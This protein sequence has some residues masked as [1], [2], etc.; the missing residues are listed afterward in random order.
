MKGLM[1]DPE[2]VYVVSKGE[3]LDDGTLNVVCH[4]RGCLLT[5]CEVEKLLKEGPLASVDSTLRVFEL[6]G[7]FT[8]SHTWE[9]RE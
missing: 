4:K 9:F 2:K 6:K 5:S 1:L 7:T 3:V 8:A